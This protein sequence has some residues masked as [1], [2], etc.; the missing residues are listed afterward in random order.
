MSIVTSEAPSHDLPAPGRRVYCNRTLNMRGI[1]A[2]GCDMDY[3]LVHY[4]SDLWEER[5]YGHAR[6]AMM[7][8]G[9]PVEQLRFDP[10]LVTRGLVLDLELGNIVKASRF[11]YVT[12]ASHGT[13][14]LE[15]E[16]QRQAY[17]GT[18]IDLSES[19]WVF[20][21]TLFSLSEGCLY[22]QL[23]DLL[24][25]GHL[26]QPMAYADVYRLVQKYLGIAHT[27]DKV[28]AEI[29]ADPQRF[30]VTDS[31]LPLALLDLKYAGKKLM[32]ITNSEW[33]YTQSMMRYAFD[34]HLP[35]GMTFRDLFDLIVVEARKPSFFTSTAALFELVDEA[36]GLFRPHAGKMQSG[37]VYLGGHARLIEDYLGVPGESI[38]YL[39]D[40][41]YA[42]VHVSKD[43]LR[44]RTALI[45]HELE[46]ELSDQDATRSERAE[47]ATLMKKKTEL[48]H[49]TAVLRLQ[50]QR[51]SAGY[52]GVNAEAAH[53]AKA[54]LAKLRTELVELDVRVAPLASTLSQCFS[55]RWGP[56]MRAGSD[57]SRMARTLERYA[58]VY[59]S[60]VSNLLA[61]GPY[62]YLRA[63]GGSLPHD[64]G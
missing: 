6:K 39:G 49:R 50:V 10:S 17:A 59:M 2:V 46:L 40:H 42:D 27:E 7:D 19:R 12:R 4:R 30:I 54:E 34:P 63:S 60:R 8:A 47:L 56:L 5:A 41:L 3:T 43:I 62:A 35:N 26:P 9:L 48:E 21:N 23:V 28:K 61:Y 31:D 18:L 33:S 64:P 29:V 16:S 37:H 22:A 13:H 58:D 53:A 14:M 15:H 45:V 55:K 44:W 20:L 24:D 1:A 36:R 32:I 57:K 38:L 11:G 25:Q 51:G 52:G